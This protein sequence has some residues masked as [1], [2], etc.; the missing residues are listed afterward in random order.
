MG[1]KP[2]SV[3]LS[4]EDTAFI[5]QHGKG[6]TEAL[7]NI[8]QKLRTIETQPHSDIPSGTSTDLLDPSLPK[9]TLEARREL[10]EASKRY[11][12]HQPKPP[13]CPFCA[14]ISDAEIECGKLLRQGKKPLKMSN[15]S[16]WAC[17]D[18]RE[19]I[20]K[21]VEKQKDNESKQIGAP[22]CPN[23]KTDYKGAENDPNAVH[24][25]G[26]EGGLQIY[27]I[28]GGLWKPLESCWECFKGGKIGTSIAV[29]V[30]ETPTNFGDD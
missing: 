4:D 15:S 30:S 10:I 7:E 29:D 5:L 19:Y 16:C 25:F 26:N 23:R 27:C 20:R 2:F 24:D 12:L 3:K 13:K 21:K 1:K 6:K 11:E 22:N 17:Y 8:L 14:P 9:E 28:D 18:R